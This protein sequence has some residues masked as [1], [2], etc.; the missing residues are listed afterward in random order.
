MMEGH[1]DEDDHNFD[2]YSL[3]TGSSLRRRSTQEASEARERKE[4]SDKKGKEVVRCGV[5]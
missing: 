3:Y 1:R 5:A 4:G 2:P